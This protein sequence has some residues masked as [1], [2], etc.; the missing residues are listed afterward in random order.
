MK[1]RKRD[2]GYVLVVGDSGNAAL[3]EEALGVAVEVRSC[4]GPGAVPCPAA[5][6]ATCALRK[7]ARASV[8]YLTNS[9]DRHSTLPCFAI[10]GAPAVGVIEGSVLPLHSQDGYALV[11]SCG[12][13]LGVLEAVAALTEPA[14]VGAV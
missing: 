8:V 3:V 6:G 2:A 11:G 9:E 1:R 10:E 13:T 7:H 14:V 4:P 5:T 12:G